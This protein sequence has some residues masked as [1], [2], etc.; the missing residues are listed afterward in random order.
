MEN[1]MAAPDLHHQVGKH[2]GLIQS[3]QTDVS[4][5]KDDVKS[6]LAS[7]N[8]SKGGWKVMLF[9]SSLAGSCGAVAYKLISVA[10]IL[11]K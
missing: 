4:E 3:L 10:W 6:I 5:I 11:P 7:I 8:E 2:E 9:M 1:T